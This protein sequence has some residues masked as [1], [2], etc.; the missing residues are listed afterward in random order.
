MFRLLVYDLGLTLS[1]KFRGDS[2]RIAAEAFILIATLHA[3]TP[4]DDFSNDE[5][6][7]FPNTRSSIWARALSPKVAFTVVSDPSPSD[8]YE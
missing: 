3:D 4:R 8:T 6:H 1:L 5:I 2:I 7:F